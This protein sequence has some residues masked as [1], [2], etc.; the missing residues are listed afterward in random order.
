MTLV[1]SLIVSLVLLSTAAASAYIVPGDRNGGGVRPNPPRGTTPLPTPL[2]PPDRG[3]PYPDP[4]PNDPYDPGYGQTEQKSVFL[5]R[6]YINETL[7]LRQLLGLERQYN[8]YIVESVTVQVRGAD[9]SSRLELIVNDYTVDTAFSPS[10]LIGLFPRQGSKLGRDINTLRL[11]VVSV[12]DIESIT[13]HLRAGQG[14]GY[15]D[16][17]GYGREEVVPLNVYQQMGAYGSL[18]LSRYIDLGRYRGLRIQSIEV[19][20]SARY[21]SALMSVL[22]NGFNQGV[23]HNL[24]QYLQTYV[25]YPQN[26]VIG[27]GAESIVLKT[28]GEQTIHRVI[29]RMTRR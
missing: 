21:G 7:P 4:Y 26:A 1:K 13:V 27:R 24:N 23:T 17:G 14:G 25:T 29:L 5:N 3:T 6:R 9:Y 2:P 28:Q 19:E 11:R 12:V 18:D 8:G 20:A 15:P 10:G 16:D 22:I